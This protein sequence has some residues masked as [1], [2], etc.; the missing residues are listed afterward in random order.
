MPPDQFSERDEWNDTETL[1]G[2]RRIPRYNS[3]RASHAGRDRFRQLAGIPSA[4][5]VVG[6]NW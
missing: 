4:W 6:H 1:R 5:V 3:L 2:I